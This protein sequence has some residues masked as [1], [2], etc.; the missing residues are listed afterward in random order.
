MTD[1]LNTLDQEEESGMNTATPKE[2][3]SPNV[4]NEQERSKLGV[5]G[6][7]A[8]EYRERHPI[9]DP[10]M[11]EERKES[12]DV[13]T[14]QLLFIEALKSKTLSLTVDQVEGLIDAQNEKIEASYDATINIGAVIEILDC[15]DGKINVFLLDGFILAM[16]Q[17]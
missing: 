10:F 7:F 13:H 11:T 1:T 8:E 15:L 17:R 5:F 2:E 14:A 3:T 6:V 9:T 12:I 16:R 4:E